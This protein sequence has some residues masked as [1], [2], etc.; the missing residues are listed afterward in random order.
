MQTKG[1]LQRN[2]RMINSFYAFEPFEVKDIAVKTQ[3]IR[4]FHFC[5]CQELCNS[6]AVCGESRTYSFEAEWERV[7]SP[8]TVTVIG[9]KNVK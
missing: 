9:N 8:S 6:G 3:Q 1:G 7:T 2:L 5:S 4:K